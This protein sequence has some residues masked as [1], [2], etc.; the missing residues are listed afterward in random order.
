M[1]NGTFPD[2]TYEARPGDRERFVRP[3]SAGGA[4]GPK[5]RSRFPYVE[6]TPPDRKPG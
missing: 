3:A 2:W 5:P 1:R 6:P 4:V